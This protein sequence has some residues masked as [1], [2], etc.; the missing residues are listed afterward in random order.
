MQ[1]TCKSAFFSTLKPMKPS[2]TRNN[3][4]RTN[5]WFSNLLSFILADN[6]LGFYFMEWP[7]TCSYVLLHVRACNI[8]TVIHSLFAEYE[9]IQWHRILTTECGEPLPVINRSMI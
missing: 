4:L 2:S 7:A 3:I 5:L 6:A 8:V 1:I 9:K